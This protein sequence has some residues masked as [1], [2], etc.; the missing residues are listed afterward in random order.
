MGSVDHLRYIFH[1]LDAELVQDIERNTPGG[2][3][4]LCQLYSLQLQLERERYKTSRKS[5]FEYLA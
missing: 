4:M 3:K 2:L 5:V 1:N